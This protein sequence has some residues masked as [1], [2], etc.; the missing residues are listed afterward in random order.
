MAQKLADIINTAGSRATILVANRDNNTK[1]RV[2]L[3][4]AQTL[5]DRNGAAVPMTGCRKIYMIFAP[6]FDN[7]EP[8]LQD[9]CFLIAGA[10]ASDATW[11]P[12]STFCFT[13]PSVG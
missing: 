13:L 4:F 2:T 11:I 12:G 8:D 5:L 1:Y 6:R 10:G 3:D 9:G 7:V